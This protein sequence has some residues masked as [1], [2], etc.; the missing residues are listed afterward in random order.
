MEFLRLQELS[1]KVLKPALARIISAL[2]VFLLLFS[3]LSISPSSPS[4]D[5]IKA[6]FVYNFAKFIEWPDMAEKQAI[7]VGYFGDKPLSGNLA[8]LV[9][10]KVKDLGIT[11]FPVD[12]AEEIVSADIIFIPGSEEKRNSEI[13][14]LVSELPVLLVSDAPDFVRNGG[15]IG[16]K[17]AGNRLRFDVNLKSANVKGLKISSQLLSLAMEVIR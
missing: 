9:N 4:E 5:E 15:T 6:A 13:I 2:A 14:K 3:V 17:I 8:L 7:R 10:R 11:V 16:L 1:N 12:N